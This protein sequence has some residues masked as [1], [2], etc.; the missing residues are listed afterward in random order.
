MSRDPELEKLRQKRM[1]D[2]VNRKPNFT[3]NDGRPIELTDASFDNTIRNYPLMLVDFWAAWCGPCRMIS[4]I[5]EQLA[6][7]YQGKVWFGKLNVDE[8]PVTAEKFGIRSIPSLLLFKNGVEIDEVVGAV[9]KS[10]LESTI[11]AHLT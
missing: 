5:V 10:V 8:N 11:T 1:A 3:N 9:P 2:L 4:P 6:H 7:E